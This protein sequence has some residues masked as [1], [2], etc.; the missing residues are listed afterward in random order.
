MCPAAG[1][2]IGQFSSE[3]K[4]SVRQL[5]ASLLSPQAQS[6]AVNEAYCTLKCPYAR[7]VYMLREFGWKFE[8]ED[9]STADAEF[10]M[11]VPPLNP[12]SPLT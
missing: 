5:N 12:L 4:A 8:E 3:S 10:M 6:A 2:F 11:K 9:N 1:L 7:A